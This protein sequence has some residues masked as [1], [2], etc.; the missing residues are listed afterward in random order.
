LLLLRRLQSRVKIDKYLRDNIKG[1]AELAAFSAVEPL[2]GVRRAGT[3]EAAQSFPGEFVSGNYF[4]MFG[5][6][7]C[8]GRVFAVSDDRAGAPPVAVMSYHLWQARYGSDASVVGSFFNLNPAPLVTRR[9][10]TRR[11]TT[12][13]P[14]SWITESRG[15]V[16]PTC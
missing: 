9:N 3:S 2:F 5:I 14:K 13:E 7:G 1:F 12:Q 10:V 6:Q 15:S 11:E 8:A 4:S 16:Y